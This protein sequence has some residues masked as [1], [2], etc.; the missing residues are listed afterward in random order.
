[1]VKAR[2]TALLF[3][4]WII[5]FF[6]NGCSINKMATKAVANALTGAGASTV[7][8]GDSDPRLV[9]DALPFAIK[10]YEALLDM[11][12]DHQGLI[13]TTGSLFV[14]YANAFV[15]GPAE[16]LP[17]TEYRERR[18]ERERARLL[19]LRSVT[20]LRSGLDKKYPGFN[21]A[22]REGKLD[23]YL[24][25][26]QKADV[27]LL[28]WTVAGSLAAYS[29]DPFNLELGMRIP[30]LSAM[31]Q[32]AYELDPEFNDGALDDFYVLFYASLPP[33]LGGDKTKADIHFNL[34]LERSKGMSA[35]PYVTYAQAV[36]IPA[37][38]YETF[39]KYLELALAVDPD[40]NPANRLVNIISRR[41][42]QFLLDHAPD[43]FLNLAGED[44]DDDDW[45]DAD[46]EEG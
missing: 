7:F 36:S 6:L 38:D 34:A 13:L 29:L 17:R 23:S 25:R 33:F 22:G 16:M 45:D 10:I 31:L 26:T 2:N 11:Q 37:Q 21:E 41:K 44:W 27:P 30:E 46:W 32:R 20:I 18:E 42:A 12:P 19:Y 3:G 43:Y 39:K 14:M 35:G 28:Y 9:G 15:Q 8:T 40:A 1:M 24:A 5:M 4:C